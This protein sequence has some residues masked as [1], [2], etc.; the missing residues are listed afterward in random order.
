M[1]KKIDLKFVAVET[2]RVLLH[3]DGTPVKVGETVTSFRGETA[4]VTGWPNDGYNR[5][6]VKWNDK[7]TFSSSY[8]PS[9][10]DLKWAD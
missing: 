5:V 10:F 4:T 6:Y 2:I 3:K 8:F 7:E 9:V 1:A